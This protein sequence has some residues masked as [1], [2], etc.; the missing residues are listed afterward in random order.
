MSDTTPNTTESTGIRRQ[1]AGVDLQE[2]AKRHGTPI[3]AYDASVIRQRCADLRDWDTVRFAQKACSNLAILDLVRREGVLVDAVS[4]GEIARA[5]AAGY[6]TKSPSEGQDNLPAADPIVYTAD[7]FDHESLEAVVQHGIH[8]NCGSADMLEQLA[9]RVPGANVTLRIN[10]GF[11]HGHSQKTNTG[12]EGSKHG[13]WHEAIP[14]VL[15]RAEWAGLAVT[16]LHMH[17]GSGADLDHLA[18]VAESLEKTAHDIGRSLTTISAGGGLPVPYQKDERRADLSEYFKLWD[19]TRKRLEDSFGHRIRLEIEPGR[20][21]T[22]E[23]GILVTEVRAVKR[24]GSKKYL[25]VDAGFH[26]LARPVLYGSYHP[27]SLCPTSTTPPHE[28]EAVAIGGPL[29]ES[30]DIFTQEEGGFVSTRDLPPARVGDLLV[31]EVAGAYG[32]VMASNYNSKPFPAEVLID[33]GTSRLVRARQTAEELFSGES[34]PQ[35]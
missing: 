23:A 20:Y 1:F 9:E 22:A 13:I 15:Q 18:T 14:D 7:I 16:G 8:V 11:G 17:I 19:A 25:L 2:L 6:S 33:G 12:G 21:L 28:L 29:C 34:L 24:Q 26:T 35:E 5:I 10:P 31:I 3:Y 32:F 27:M 30:G 4:H